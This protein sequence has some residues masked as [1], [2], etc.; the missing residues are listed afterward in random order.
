MRVWPSVK[1]KT[2]HLSSKWFETRFGHKS[3][4]LHTAEPCCRGYVHVT[5]KHNARSCYCREP[6]AWRSVQKSRLNLDQSHLQGFGDQIRSALLAPSRK[7]M[8]FSWC[9]APQQQIQ[10][11]GETSHSRTYWLTQLAVLLQC[12]QH[13]RIG[14]FSWIMLHLDSA[15]FKIGMPSSAKNLAYVTVS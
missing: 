6:C 12:M 8:S 4:A 3:L 10:Y 13:H 5:S 14:C 1:S 15:A 11:F 9:T 2:P 7:A